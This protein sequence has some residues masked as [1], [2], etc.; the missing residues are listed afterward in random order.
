MRAAAF[1][2]CES[3]NQE[4]QAHL[5]CPESTIAEGFRD[6]TARQWE[7]GQS[8]LWREQSGGHYI[9]AKPALVRGACEPALPSLF[10][11]LVLAK[12][13]WLLQGCPNRSVAEFDD[14]EKSCDDVLVQHAVDDTSR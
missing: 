5:N 12:A 7:Y 6:I 3:Q 1:R 11:E 8:A 14:V 9:I 13:S 2:A 4:H 10:L